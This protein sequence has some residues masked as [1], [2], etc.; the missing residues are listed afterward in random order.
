MMRRPERIVRRD[1]VVG[2]GFIYLLVES[3]KDERER[4]R[5]NDG[6]GKKGTQG[7]STP[8]TR[9]VAARRPTGCRRRRRRRKR[10]G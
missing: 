7:F 3:G 10:L 1:E 5:G 6:K 4:E 8:G 9:R 2:G